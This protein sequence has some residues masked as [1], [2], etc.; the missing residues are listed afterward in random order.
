[1]DYELWVDNQTYVSWTQGTTQGYYPAVPPYP[2][3][4]QGVLEILLQED[5]TGIELTLRAR[6]AVGHGSFGDDIIGQFC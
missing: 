2:R 5:L 1:L 3:G 6:N 4:T